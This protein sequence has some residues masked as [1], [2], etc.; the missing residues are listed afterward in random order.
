MTTL[1]P[2][3]ARRMEPR[4]PHPRKR[5]DAIGRLSAAGIPVMVIVAPIIPSLNDHEI[6]AILARGP[7]L[8]AGRPATC[9]C[10]CRTN[11]MTS[12]P[13]GSPSITR[14]DNAT[15]CHWSAQARGGK[16]YDA[17]FGKRMTGT[18]A[19]A[20]LIRERMRLARRGSA[21]RSRAAPAHR[22]VQGSDGP[23]EPVLR[24]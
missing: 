20:D 8:G 15:S 19:Y 16:A 9:C 24:S 21:T 5:L 7:R 6:E 10:A 12:S 18:G 22:P 2:V 11:S 23:A 17:A 1:D 3:L 14:A 4:A 13:T